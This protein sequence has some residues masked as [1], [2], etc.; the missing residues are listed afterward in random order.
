MTHPRWIVTAALCG[1][2]TSLY[3]QSARDIIAFTGIM[4]TPVGA[5]SPVMTNTLIDRF[6]NGASLALRYGHLSSG[7]FNS[8]TNS[9]GVTGVLPAGL[10][11]SV[12]LT[13]GVTTCQGCDAA[14]L[15]GV[16]GDT[17]LYASPF[18]STSTSPLVT[19]SLDGQLG[20]GHVRSTSYFSGYVGAPVALVGR[21]V[22]MQFVPFITPGFGF[23]QQSANG[24]SSSGSLFMVG[25]GLGV[26]N[27][28]TNVS[29]NLGFQYPFVTNGTTMIGLTLTLGGK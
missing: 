25:G 11:S 3:A 28:V 5:L 24:S 15:L 20:F 23:A 6:Q 7:D 21:G 12:S 22:G 10:G 18:G 8:A 14:L 29:A 16:G 27:K 26:Y 2:A 13:G 1:L 17:R 9:V 4:T 19:L